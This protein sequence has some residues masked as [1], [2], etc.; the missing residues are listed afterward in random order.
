M[1]SGKIKV[2]AHELQCRIEGE[3][4]NPW[5]IL[6]NSLATDH[7]MWQPQ[8]DTLTRTHRV[9]RYD[10][11]GH[12]ESAAPAGPYAFDDLVSD[13]IGLMDALEIEKATFMGLSLGGMTALGLAL[14]HPDRIERILCCD[15]RADAPDLYKQMWPAMIKKARE[16]GMDAL[17]A[18]TL[19]RWFSTNFRTNPTNRPALE[20]TGDMIRRTAVEGYAGCA[21]ALMRLDYLPRLSQIAIPAHFIVGEHDPAAPPNVMREMAAATPGADFTVIPGA[22]HLSNVERPDVFNDIVATWLARS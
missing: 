13:V 21:S 9:L 11:R 22:A 17:V 14:D 6:S 16:E 3:A 15:A 18:P 7:A 5:L 8:I 4:G 2:G 20:A 1:T 12:G 10:T 19:E